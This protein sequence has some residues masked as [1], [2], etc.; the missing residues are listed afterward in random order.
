MFNNQ[1]ILI[2]GGTGSFGM[3]YIKIILERYRPKKNIVLSQDELKQ[4]SGVIVANRM[5]SNIED[6]EN[7]VYIRDLFGK[8]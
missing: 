3:K 8:N 2:T 7:K 5:T 1:T 4:L 6:V